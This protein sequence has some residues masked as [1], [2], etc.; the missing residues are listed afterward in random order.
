MTPQ[1]VIACLLDQDEPEHNLAAIEHRQRLIKSWKIPQGSKVLEVGPG[2][3]DFTVCLADAVGPTGQVVAVDPAPLDW[4]T[5][6]YRTAQGFVLRSPLGSRIQFVQA[7]PID[8]LD[9]PT[10]AT[11]S[12]DF[13]VFCHSIWYFSQP[14][15]LPTMLSK[16]RPCVANVL[17][18][19]YSLSTSHPSAVPHVLASLAANAVE[20]FR[21]EDSK[22]NIRC[23]LTPL[24]MI[25]AAEEVGWALSHEETVTPGEKQLDAFREVNMILKSRL[26][27]A[28]M[29]SVQAGDKVK[30]MLQSMTYAV[31]ASVDRLDGRLESVRNMDVWVARFGAKE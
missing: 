19:E 30:T 10:T 24:R 6:D 31:K 23:A 11:K 14:S 12:F 26:F 18:A 21:G 5:P 15:F 9:A 4:G 8:F 27:K 3:G 22:R 17:I 2:Q 1:E 20:S 25:E 13:I 28:D 7:D 29:E 16:A